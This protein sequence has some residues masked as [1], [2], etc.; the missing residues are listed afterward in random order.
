MVL[1][2]DCRPQD[3]HTRPLD[4][5]DEDEIVQEKYEKYCSRPPSMEDVSYFEFLER[6]NFQARNPDNWKKWQSPSKPRVLYFSPR[7]KPLRGHRQF[8]DF[9]RIKL[10][11]NHPHREHDDLTVN[12]Q[13]FDDYILAYEYCSRNHEHENDHYGEADNP[14]PD[15]DPDDQPAGACEASARPVTRRRACRSPLPPRHRCELRL[16]DH[17]MSTDIS[18]HPFP[19]IGIRGEQ[20]RSL[21]VESMLPEARETLNPEQRLVYDMKRTGK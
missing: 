21:N 1:S 14:D 4:F 15:A 9:C 5:S 6:C 11:L 19:S 16:V 7:Y 3:K 18:T 13:H 12:G 20:V 10:L 8:G 17:R 2:V